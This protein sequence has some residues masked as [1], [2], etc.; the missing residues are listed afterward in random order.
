MQFPPFTSF[1]PLSRDS[2][3][4]IVIKGPASDPYDQ[5]EIISSTPWS[6]QFAIFPKKINGEWVWL[7]YYWMR[8]SQVKWMNGMYFQNEFTTVF[9][10]LAN[11]K[12][13]IEIK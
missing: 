1:S 7:D 6:E 9:G 5:H 8:T 11:E 10:K 2:F 3:S 13:Y 4:Q 12:P